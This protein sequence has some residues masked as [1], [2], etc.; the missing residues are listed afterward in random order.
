LF[1]CLIKFKQ[2][3]EK[4]L[5]TLSPS[6]DSPSIC[7]LPDVFCSLIDS[8]FCQGFNSVKRFVSV[9]PLCQSLTLD[10]CLFAG[11]RNART[12]KQ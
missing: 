7:N 12:C 10:I 1:N 6:L 8:F 9:V 4:G 3:R 5:A 11:A 2:G